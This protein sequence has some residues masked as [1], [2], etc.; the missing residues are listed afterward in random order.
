MTTLKT[1]N[2]LNHVNTQISFGEHHKRML[3]TLEQCLRK[4]LKENNANS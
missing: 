3:D 1:L 4:F 2:V